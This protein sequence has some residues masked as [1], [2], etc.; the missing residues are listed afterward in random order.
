MGGWS[1]RN[2]DRDLV[3]FHSNT[4]FHKALSLYKQN[5]TGEGGCQALVGMG[6]SKVKSAFS[7]GVSPFYL[8]LFPTSLFPLGFPSSL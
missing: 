8:V 6:L 3:C 2:Q 1:W 4:G 7:E 5:L